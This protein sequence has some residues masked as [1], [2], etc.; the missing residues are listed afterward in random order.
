MNVSQHVSTAQVHGSESES[1]LVYASL[2]TERLTLAL[3]PGDIQILDSTSSPLSPK[4]S[5]AHMI[6]NIFWNSSGC[7]AED[8][9]FG[10]QNATIGQAVNTPPKIIMEPQNWWFLNVSPFPRRY[11]QVPCWFSGVYSHQTL[12]CVDTIGKCQKIRQ[13]RIKFNTG[14]QHHPTPN[15]TFPANSLG[16]TF[17]LHGS[18]ML[19]KRRSLAQHNSHNPLPPPLDN[20]RPQ[21]LPRSI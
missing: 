2:A 13:E 16:A 20:C 12:S 1:H 6:P 9:S 8:C 3:Q 5:W 14:S 18:W 21:M 17:D 10:L 7:V 4:Q 15:G 11:F 19:T